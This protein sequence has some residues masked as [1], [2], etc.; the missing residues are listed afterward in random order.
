MFKWTGKSGRRNSGGT[1]VAQTSRIRSP[2]NKFRQATVR[3]LHRVAFLP[4]T[5]Q[6]QTFDSNSPRLSGLED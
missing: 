3:E 1:G 4:D 5:P 2:M 6:E